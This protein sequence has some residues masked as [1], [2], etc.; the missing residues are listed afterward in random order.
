MTDIQITKLKAHG[1]EQKKTVFQKY[2]EMYPEFKKDWCTDL[3]FFTDV[4]IIGTISFVLLPK[5]RTEFLACETPHRFVTE[6]W[7]NKVTE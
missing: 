3:Y 6:K 2:T 1:L 5:Y 7:G 4:F